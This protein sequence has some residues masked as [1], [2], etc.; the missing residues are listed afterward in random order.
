M[1][2]YKELTS[3]ELIPWDL[4]SKEIFSRMYNKDIIQ[5]RKVSKQCYIIVDRWY[6]HQIK[7]KVIKAINEKCDLDDMESEVKFLKKSERCSECKLVNDV[8]EFLY[9]KFNKD[10]DDLE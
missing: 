10:L 8:A 9:D 1:E 4:W 5:I 3:F 6:K 7:P 2:N